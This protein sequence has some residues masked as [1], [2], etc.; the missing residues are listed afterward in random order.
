MKKSFFYI[1]LTVLIEV[2]LSI[3]ISMYFKTAL[4]PVMFFIGLLFIAIVMFFTS[5]GGALSNYNN[6]V[7]QAQ[8]GIPIN[9]RSPEEL[10]LKGSPALW[11]AGIYFLISLGLFVLY[12]NDFI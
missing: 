11:G 7:A 6:A 12:L 8:T 5:S 4:I 2:G 10:K 9:D 1:V 3:G